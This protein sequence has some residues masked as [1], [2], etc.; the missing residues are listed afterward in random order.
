MK[1]LDK[2]H[3]ELMAGFEREYKHHRLTREEDKAFWKRGSIYQ[4]GHVNQLFLA[5][6]RG[7][8][9]GKVVQRDEPDGRPEC[10]QYA[11]PLPVVGYEK[12]GMGLV[13]DP[14]AWGV[15]QDG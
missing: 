4:D 6:R 11:P 12:S 3:Y 5:Y 8:A 15:G 9:L 7:Y 14:E 10:A 1:I 13:F 2:E